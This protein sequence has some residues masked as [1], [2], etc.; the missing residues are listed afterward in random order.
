MFMFM[1]NQVSPPLFESIEMLGRETVL[2]RLAAA[3]EVAVD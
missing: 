2:K 1:C 3:A